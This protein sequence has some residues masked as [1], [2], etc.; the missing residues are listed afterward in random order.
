VDN[1]LSSEPELGG[2]EGASLQASTK[3]ADG[4]CVAKL[5]RRRKDITGRSFDLKDIFLSP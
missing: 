5:D 4:I 1:S 3:S 2:S